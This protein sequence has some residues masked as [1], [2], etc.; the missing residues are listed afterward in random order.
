MKQSYFFSAPG[1]TE[2]SGNQVDHQ[3]GCVLAGAVN[4][5]SIAEVKLNDTNSICID[6]EGYPVVKI[7]LED[8]AVREEEN[9]QRLPW[10]GVLRQPSCSAG[11][12]CGALMPVSVPMSCLAAVSALLLLLKC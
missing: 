9:I 6:S 8:L 2:I 12:S 7:D 1:R 11:V 10:S 4:L 3:N 5:Q